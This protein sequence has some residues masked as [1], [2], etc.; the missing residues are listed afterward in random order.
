MLVFEVTT[1]GNKK[2]DTMEYIKDSESKTCFDI[3][4]GTAT[5]S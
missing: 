3:S 1:K 4:L 5:T 2:M